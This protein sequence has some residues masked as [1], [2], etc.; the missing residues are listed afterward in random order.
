VLNYDRLIKRNFAPVEQSYTT[1]ESI[2]YALAVG[3]G[4]DPCDERELPFVYEGTPKVAPTLP[5]VLGSPGFWLD[6]PDVGIDWRRAVHAAQ[7]ITIHAPLPSAGR[8]IGKTAITGIVDRG[9][10]RGALLLT[11]RRLYEDATGTLVASMPSATLCRGEGGFGG[12]PDQAPPPHDLPNSPADVCC[13]VET[14]PRSPMLYRLFGDCNPLHIDAS[15]A[16]AAG[17]PRPIMHGLGS[18]GLAART[19][20]RVVC[21]YNTSLL[22][23]IEARFTAALFPGETLRFELWHHGHSVSFRAKTI[24]REAVVLDRGMVVIGPLGGSALADR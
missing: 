2:L 21:D 3:Y 19:I 17:F 13:D 6:A 4:A 1:R 9:E 5:L 22:R 12:S 16:H 8:V 11:E 20:L 23:H 10:G 18:L 7:G 14:S 24:G 15:A